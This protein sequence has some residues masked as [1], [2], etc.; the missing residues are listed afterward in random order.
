MIE[1]GILRSLR[2]SVCGDVNDVV[3]QTEVL[4]CSASLSRNGDDDDVDD[5]AF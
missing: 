4:C 1:L 2:A 5:V 3:L